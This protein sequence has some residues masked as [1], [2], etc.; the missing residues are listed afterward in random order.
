MTL[1]LLAGTREAREIAQAL[2]AENTPALASLA[3][4]TR[5]PTKLAIPTRIGGFGGAEGFRDYL[6]GNKIKAVLDATHPFAHLISCRSAEVCMTE[7]VPYCQLLR[8]AWKPEPD[9]HVLEREEEA[10]ALVQPGETVFLATGRQTLDRFANLSHARVICR[11]ID[12][13]EAPFPFANGHY[14]VAK[15]PFSEDDEYELFQ[16]LGVDWL[17]AKNAGGNSSRTKLDA[18]K[19]LK[20]KVALLARPPHPAGDKAQ[21]VEDALAWVARL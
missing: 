17:I 15:P 3:G 21:T 20:I 9:W 10:A 18:A 5:E 13:P 4:V 8:K 14:H 19:R 12:P 2:A 1:L 6:L 7:S 16:E 11:Q